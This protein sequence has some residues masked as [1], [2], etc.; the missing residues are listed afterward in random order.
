MTIDFPDRRIPLDQ[1]H[2]DP[3]RGLHMLLDCDRI[4][5]DEDPAKAPIERTDPAWYPIALR[6]LA[7]SHPV[8]SDIL[9]AAAIQDGTGH[10]G[11]LLH[12]ALDYPKVNSVVW[13]AAIQEGHR[14]V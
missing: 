8:I 11:V 13:A 9:W 4:H 3:T 7:A 14:G 6:R 2:Y 1:L 10:M 5:G 12:L